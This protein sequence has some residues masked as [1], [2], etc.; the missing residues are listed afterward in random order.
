MKTR[1]LAFFFF[2]KDKI[3]KPLTGLTKKKRKRTQVNKQ[4]KMI[5]NNQYNRDTKNRKKTLW[6][7]ICQ[8]T[9]KSGINGQISRSTQSAKSE[10][11]RNRWFK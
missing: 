7:V 3:D 6:I 4:W 5:N 9:G 1:A 2:F 11:S 8:Q 10:S